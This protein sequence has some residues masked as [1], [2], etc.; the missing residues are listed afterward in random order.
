MLLVIKRANA[1]PSGQRKEA[2]KCWGISSDLFWRE[3]N[4]QWKD[5]SWLMQC[6]KLTKPVLVSEWEGIRS[7]RNSC[8]TLLIENLHWDFLSHTTCC[9]AF[10]L[11]FL[12]QVHPMHSYRSCLSCYVTF[13]SGQSIKKKKVRSIVWFK[14]SICVQLSA[15]HASWNVSCWDPKLSVELCHNKQSLYT[16]RF[17]TVLSTCEHIVEHICFTQLQSMVL[18]KKKGAS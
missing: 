1:N 13:K 9:A 4:A 15:P 5:K 17:F 12:S 8:F 18:L 7:Y 10:F 2:V 14:S 3:Q 11:F 6:T 16:H